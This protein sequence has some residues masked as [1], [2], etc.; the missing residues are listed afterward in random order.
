MLWIHVGFS[1]VSSGINQCSK[2]ENSVVIVFHQLEYLPYFCVT[3]LDRTWLTVRS[4]GLQF[5][6]MNSEMKL[7]TLT[8]TNITRIT[9]IY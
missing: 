2:P 7:Q 8:F 3:S 6:V 9:G 1:Q 4:T 5:K